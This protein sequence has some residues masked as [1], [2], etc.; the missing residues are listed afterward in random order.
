MGGGSPRGDVDI[1]ARILVIGS[2]CVPSHWA[3]YAAGDSSPER[4][5]EKG[6]GKKRIFDSL[7]PRRALATRSRGRVVISLSRV[8][9]GIKL[10]FRP[11]QRLDDLRV[12]ISACNDRTRISSHERR[13]RYTGN[14][15]YLY[16]AVKL[17]WRLKSRAPLDRAGFNPTANIRSGVINSTAMI[18]RLTFIWSCDLRGG[19][20]GGSPHTKEPSNCIHEGPDIIFVVQ[21]FYFSVFSDDRISG[22]RFSRW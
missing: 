2:R 13:D 1:G 8:S 18:D 10:Q 4:S 12:L 6:I 7:S 11:G 21:H 19:G 5:V 3:R 20:R 17:F 9:S 16:D 14:G 22:E 15:I